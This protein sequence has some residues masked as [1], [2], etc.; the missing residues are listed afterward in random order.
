[1]ASTRLVLICGLPASGKTMLARRLAPE[2][3]AIRLYEPP[4]EEELRSFDPPVVA[5]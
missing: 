4:T 1:M 2:I 5:G 3:P